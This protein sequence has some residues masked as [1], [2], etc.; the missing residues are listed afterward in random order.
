MSLYQF[1]MLTHAGEV[2]SKKTWS[3]RKPVHGRKGF[4]VMEDYQPQQQIIDTFLNRK[5][6]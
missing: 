4:S 6:L 2:F 3:V 1:G 5:I